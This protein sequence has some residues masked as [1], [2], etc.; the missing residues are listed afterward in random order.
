MKGADY[1]CGMGE[2]LTCGGRAHIPPPTETVPSGLPVSGSTSPAGSHANVPW[3]SARSESGGSSNSDWVPHPN[4]ASRPPSLQGAP[5][6]IQEHGG[7]S[8]VGDADEDVMPGSSFLP[9]GSSSF[10]PNFLLFPP[11]FCSMPSS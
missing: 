3:G 1:S 9:S 10:F 6:S 5:G 11:K 2:M 8:V 4:Y 7:T